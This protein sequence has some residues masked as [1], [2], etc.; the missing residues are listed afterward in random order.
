[1]QHKITITIFL[2]LFSVIYNANGQKLVNS[3]YSRFNIG[4]IQPGGSYRSLA[5]GGVGT[6]LRDNCNIIISNP[7]SYSSLDTTSFL[8]DFGVDYGI[9]KLSAGVSSFSTYDI[10]FDHLLMGFPISKGWGVAVGVIPYSNGYY[11]MAQS[12]LK[13]SPG[14]D[15][16]VGEYTSSHSGDGG[17]N[18]YFLGS[19]IKLNKN[20]SVGI[21]MT[22]LLGQVKR[23]N[24]F[25][26]VEYYNVFNNNS[27]ETL[28][29]SGLN[30]DY[31]LQYSTA[32]KND[33]F[34]NAGISLSSPKYYSSNFEHLSYTYTAYGNRDTIS[35]ISDNLTKAFIPGTLRV[36][37]SS[38]K[39]DK[40]TAALDYTVTKWSKSKIPGSAGYAADTRSYLFGAE[41]IPDKY[42]N[43]S[44][45]KRI[46][47]RVGAHFEDNYLI[48]NGE[49]VK[50]FGLSAGLGIP[51]R[52]TLSKT[53]LYFDFTRRT[54]SS[55]NNLHNEN[56]YTIGI[57]LNIYD[58]FWFIKRKYE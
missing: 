43:Y 5:M 9:N 26:F 56:Y 22:L 3:P 27:T 51:M 58:G 1:M 40:F 55:L 6:A 45:L 41:Y 35:F 37:I 31:G 13:N 20:F 18:T 47:Y 17:F 57:S 23:L 53:N 49:Q 7:A 39:R 54:G 8:F 36:G 24:Q 30:F 16:L 2:I 33:H 19:G 12:I 25:D 28:H 34:F 21:N 38:G 14:Y 29:L 48:I 11:K 15:P 44:F 32:L 52:R 42:S 4:T 10:N 46:E 50:E